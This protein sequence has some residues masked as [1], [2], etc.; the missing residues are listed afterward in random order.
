LGDPGKALEYFEQ[1]LI[2]VRKIIDRRGEG[3]SLFN[4]ALALDK[5]QDRPKAIARAKAALQIFKAIE[6]PWG[7]KARA[8]LKNWNAS[9][10]KKKPT[11]KSRSRCSP[12]PR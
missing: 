7:A 3:F 9:Q 8:V 6:H 2:V 1:R 4:S 11:G 12:R 5:L 10:N